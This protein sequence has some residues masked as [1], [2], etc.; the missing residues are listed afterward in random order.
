MTPWLHPFN[1]EYIPKQTQWNDEH[2]PGLCRALDTWN[3]NTTYILLN[4]SFYQRP[5]IP[6]P[7]GKQTYIFS[8]YIDPFDTRW[9]TEIYQCNPDSEFIVLASGNPGD[10]ANM[11]RVKFVPIYFDRVWISANKSHGQQPMIPVQKRDLYIGA[12]SARVNE[13]KYYITA[14]LL[15][16]QTQCLIRWNLSFK[17]NPIDNFIFEQTGRPQR[18]RLLAQYQEVLKHP[19]N[20]EKFD[21]SPLSNSLT[22]H[23]AYTQ[24]L[25]NSI[26]ESRCIGWEPDFGDLPGPFITEKTYKAI[27]SGTAVLFVGQHGMIPYLR[28]FGF[29]FSYPWSNYYDSV[30]GDL[31]RLELLLDQIDCIMHM[32]LSHIQEGIHSSVE[33]NYK[34]FWSGAVEDYI[35]SANSQTLLSITN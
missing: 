12:M 4:I 11:P 5:R 18:D 6:I 27:S 2:T 34:L 3:P 21:N 19:I 30:P 26:N 14:K 32:P 9:F 22:T 33:N 31:D 17:L 29:D 24:C 1:T 25:I 35:N 15:E 8:F 13:Y 28:N 20:M 7:S 23:P 10:L 16:Y